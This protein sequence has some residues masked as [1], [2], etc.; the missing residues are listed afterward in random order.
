[1]GVHISCKNFSGLSRWTDRQEMIND[2]MGQFMGQDTDMK[3]LDIQIYG[4]VIK[5]VPCP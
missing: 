4:I 5:P 1:M 2:G 3:I